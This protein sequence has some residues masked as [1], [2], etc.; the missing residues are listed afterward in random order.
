MI[1]KSTIHTIIIFNIFLIFSFADINAQVIGKSW[2]FNQNG[3]FEG[4]VLS[5]ALKDSVVENGF[6]SATVASDF[7][8]LSSD[9]FELDSKDYGF[10]YVRLKIPGASSGKIMWNNDSGNWGFM[11]FFS[12][13]DTTFQEYKIPVYQNKQWTGK[14]TKIMRLDF[15]PSIGSKIEIDYIRIVRIGA[16]PKINNFASY[17]TIYKPDQAVKL[18][19]SVSNAGDIESLLKS[20][21]ILPN[22]V[23]LLNGNIDNEHGT[24]YRESADSVGWTISFR[25][26]GIYNLTLQ[27]FND[28]D[29]TERTLTFNVNDKYWKQDEFL[30]SAWSPPYAWYGL[31]YEDEVFQ[32]YKDAHFKNVLW[33]RPEDELVSMVKKYNLKYFVLV[34]GILGGDQYLRSED[35]VEAPD[36]TEDMLLNLDAVI[37]KYKDDPNLI[38]YHICDEP[39]EGAFK[40]IGKVVQ[41]IRTK[42]PSRLSFVNIWPSGTGYGEY[43]DAL[44]QTAKLELLSYDRYHFYNGYDGG[45]YFTNIDIIRKYALKYD[46]PFCNIIQAIGTNETV[47]SGLNWRTPSEAEHRWLVYSSLT[48]GVHALIWFH[49]HGDWGLTGNPDRELIYPSIQKINAEIDSLSQIMVHLQTTGVYHSIIS[50]PKWKLPVDGIISSISE[51]ANFVIGYFSDSDLNKYF[52][53]MNKSYKDAVN[54]TVSLNGISEN[55]IYFNVQNNTWETVNTIDVNGKSNFEINLAAGGG[56]L[57]TFSSLT[58]AGNIESDKLPLK[59]KLMQNYP[60]PFNPATIIEYSIAAKENSESANAV[61]HSNDLVQLKVYSVLGEEVTT[62]VNRKQKPGNYKIEFNASDLSSGIYFYKLVSGDFIQT[63]KMLFLK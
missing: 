58:D 30:L 13:G 32:Y 22:G 19:A 9:V 43:I 56:K 60:N 21:L 54:A 44:L 11:Q 39:H 17:R 1:Y 63:K 6:L 37:D 51:N 59:F 10:I 48:Y 61:I 25:N 31:P 4:I 42:D 24:L 40:N 3:D 16:V 55:L 14:I 52:M 35:N 15:N 27:L 50:D 57:F 28:I 8:S 7:P 46:I 5:K 45:E 38:G 29:T 36:L 12:N 33:V 23:D 41:R 47:E 26:F 20:K 49:W 53:L 62:L 34:T 18:Y 2:E